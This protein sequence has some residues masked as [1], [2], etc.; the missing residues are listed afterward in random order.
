[1]QNDR[2][3]L[4]MR[5]RNAGILRP[6]LL[7]VSVVAALGHVSSAIA[8][9]SPTPSPVPAPAVPAPAVA[10]LPNPLVAGPQEVQ[11]SAS[12]LGTN[13]DLYDLGSYEKGNPVLP[14]DYLV[15]LFVNGY[16]VGRETVSF[17]VPDAGGQAQ[18][19]LTRELMTLAGVDT[20]K[21]EASGAILEGC[22][23]IGALGQGA[24]ALYDPSLLR[25][26]LSIPQIALNRR[27]RDYVDPSLWDRG[28]NAFTL[29]YSANF[30]H[31]SY[32]NGQK[33]DSAYI[34]LNSGLNIGGWRIRNQASYRW[35][36]ATG[37]DFQSI[38]TYAQHDIT[39]WKSQ[40][41]IGDSFTGSQF[42]D[43]TAFRG[44]NLATDQRMRPDST[45]GYAPSVRGT[46]E[47]NAKVEIRQQGYVIYETT[48]A[49]GAFEINDLYPNSIGGDL[50]V[51]ITEADGRT[52][53]Y[54]VPYASVPQL[55][56]PGIWNYSVTLGQV[57]DDS[58]TG[59][60]P[61]FIEGTFQKG[62][63]NWLTSYVG[64]QA[65]DGGMYRSA[66]LGGAFNSRFGAVS[67]DITGSRS[68]FDATGE[69]RNGY[70]ARIT[71]NKNIP[72]TRTD[73]AL[74]AYRYSTENYLSLAD[75]TRW[76][77]LYA[78]NDK[79]RIA[80]AEHNE[81]SRRGQLSLTVSQRLGDRGGSLYFSG[82]ATTT[83]TPPSTRPC[84]PTTASKRAGAGPSAP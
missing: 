64:A 81:H 27:P 41:T 7:M 77:D 40:L 68:T 56:R 42:F 10:P 79:D 66:M 35:D 45:N 46:A 15:D 29:S 11:F 18:A 8:G 30:N 62:I 50:E 1:M 3:K 34:G 39:R 28:I 44:V 78:S 24:T 19:C 4:S 49:P 21:L 84:R 47:S 83:G 76:N 20:A 57:R 70:S 17:R 32:G 25:L 54:T 6:S 75:A 82:C 67:M 5:S 14:G 23:D 58:L 37:S 63:N 22:I 31:G 74:A 60:A 61:T 52:R 59:E 69:S 43:S 80:Q 16:A 38:S 65:T 71:Y 13:S 73:F 72:A 48:V 33:S 26:E 53:S 2:H 36:D 12:F 51:V 55:L 9:P